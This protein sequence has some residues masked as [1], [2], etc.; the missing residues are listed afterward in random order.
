[1]KI[2]EMKL[3]KRLI[4]PQVF[5]VQPKHLEIEVDSVDGRQF[6]KCEYN[7]DGD[8]YRSPWTNKYFP[9]AASD[10]I[11]PSPDLLQLEQKANEVYQRYA[12]LYFDNTAITSVYFFDTDYDGFGAAFLTKKGKR[13]S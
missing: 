5:K 9:Q 4:N 7:R 10:S 2:L 1:M 3:C 8:A 13:F 12:S 6:L 11:Y